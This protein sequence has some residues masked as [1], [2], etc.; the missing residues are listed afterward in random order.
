LANW[1]IALREEGAE[2]WGGQ[3]PSMEDDSVTKGTPKQG[4]N[5]IPA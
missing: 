2:G 4:R 5:G 3:N 1:Q